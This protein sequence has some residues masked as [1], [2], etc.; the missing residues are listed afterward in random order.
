[1]GSDFD[2][3][4]PPNLYKR[5]EELWLHR[6]SKIIAV[7]GTGEITLWKDNPILLGHGKVL[8]VL[9]VLLL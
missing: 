8:R 9:E 1:M 7:S 6:M 3:V 2:F 4:D 5:V